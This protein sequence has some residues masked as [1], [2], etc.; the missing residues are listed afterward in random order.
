MLVKYR[1]LNSK[2]DNLSFGVFFLIFAN[3]TRLTAVKRQGGFVDFW[4]GVTNL[5]NYGQ[6]NRRTAEPAEPNKN[7]LF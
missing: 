1:T 2:S 4:E 7:H 5:W 6:R 3:F